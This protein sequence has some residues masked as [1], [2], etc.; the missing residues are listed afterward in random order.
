M[1]ELDEGMTLLL[2]A[3]FLLLL[4]VIGL[5]LFIALLS[6]T[7]QKVQDEALANSLL[8]RVRW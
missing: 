6:S 2:I 7:F 5:N 8:Q 3:P 1:R 4:A